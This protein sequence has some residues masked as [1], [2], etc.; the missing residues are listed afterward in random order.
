MG[1]NAIRTVA[2]IA[3]RYFFFENI[4]FPS[5]SIDEKEI[6]NMAELTIGSVLPGRSEEMVSGF[7]L[8]KNKSGLSV[9][10]AS[11]NRLMSE[12]P[13]LAGCNFWIPEKFFREHIAPSPL[14]SDDTVATLDVD[15]AGNLS[16]DGEKIRLFSKNFWTAE[17][18]GEVD[19]S[20]HRLSEMLN[21]VYGKIIIPIISTAS[22]LLLAFA[23]L[24]TGS[25]MLNAWKTSLDNKRPKINR[26]AARE[27]L[28]D[29]LFAFSS[30]VIDCLQHL[31]AVNN[32]RPKS[33]LFSTFYANSPKSID[34]SGTSPSIA[35]FNA[36][37]SALNGDPTIVSVATS[38][39]VSTQDKT[40]FNATV[41]FNSHGEKF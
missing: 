4:D 15:G 39:V 38:N 8:S 19:K 33:L 6:Q 18:H 3:D 7:F 29:E 10:V 17:M 30:G 36:F 21:A 35:T 41:T 12:I 2:V 14:K 37:V 28:R 34:I 1:T 32:V 24:L 26:I 27:A 13:T 22:I 9:F 23:T 5:D 20:A 16:I 11:K 25:W 40:T 31:D